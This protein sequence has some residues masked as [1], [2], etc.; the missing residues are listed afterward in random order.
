MLISLDEHYWSSRYLNN[1]TGWDVGSISTPLKQ[2]LDQILNFQSSI[3][4]PGAGNGYEVSY[5]FQKG[6][7]NL[8]ILDISALPLQEFSL[9]NP[10]FPKSQSHHEDFF[11][12]EG[13]Y[14][15]VLE[16]TF[17]CA[18]APK[19]R[20]DYAAKMHELLKPGGKLVGVLFNR[21]FQHQGP[22][23]GGSKSEYLGYFQD[24]FHVLKME[25][26]QNSI[27]ARQGSELFFVLQKPQ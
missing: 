5:A 2:Y 19:M 6:F 20:S 8:H 25:N 18:L 17:F 10:D 26:C 13:E 21:D 4:V 1:E 7:E 11:A 24:L 27:P 22:P 14:D 9:S 12:H 16:Q 15:L 3:L 23:F